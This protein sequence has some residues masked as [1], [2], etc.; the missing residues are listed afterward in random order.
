MI[1]LG[2]YQKTVLKGIAREGKQPVTIKN[3]Y[4]RQVKSLKRR[5]LIKQKGKYFYLTIFGK[6]RV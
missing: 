6:K 1:R 2:I 5:K 4:S 3:G